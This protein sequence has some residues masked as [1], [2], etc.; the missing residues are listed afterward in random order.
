LCKKGLAN[1]KVSTPKASKD[2]DQQSTMIIPT[3]RMVLE[4]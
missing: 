4:H 2:K 3:Y 1:M